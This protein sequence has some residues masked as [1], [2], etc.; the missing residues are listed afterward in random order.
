MTFYLY[1]L[2]GIIYS[3]FLV[4]LALGLLRLPKPPRLNTYQ[5]MS[6]VVAARNEEENLDDLIK[7]LSSQNYPPEN[8]EIIIVDDRSTDSTP[9]ILSRYQQH[10]P[11]LRTIRIDKENVN[12]IGKKNALDK[13]IHIAQY[14]ILVFTDADCIMGKNWLRE[15]DRY[16]TADT[17][18]LTGYS[19][20]Q[21][22]G[23]P[24]P[25]SMKNLERTVYA[26]IAAGSF[27]WKI[28]ITCTAT[29]LIYRKSLFNQ[30]KGFDSI[31]HIRSGDD[32]L[33]MLKMMPFIHK[34][35]YMTT[36]D[37]L[38][39]A[40]YNLTLNSHLSLETRRASKFRYY[41]LY[42]KSIAFIIFLIFIYFYIAFLLSLLSIFSWLFF[43][44]LFLIKTAGEVILLLPFLSRIR[45]VSLI[46]V[47]PIL[48]I[49]YPIHFLIFAFKGTFG[50]YQWK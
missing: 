10:I 38:V 25:S 29:N 2:P 9:D 26:A 1:L 43:L 16:M 37:S 40:K 3:G 32:D 5:K 34:L 28:G 44:T 14:E 22:T 46:S 47:Y 41:P 7:S 4:F 31:G 23:K 18:F 21:I 11:N 36:Q 24:V 39:V 8:Y 12:I 6:I 33:M 13:G 50:S 49:Y 30:A 35:N 20:L 48:L 17:D 27:G 45:R 19:T 15:I 42:L